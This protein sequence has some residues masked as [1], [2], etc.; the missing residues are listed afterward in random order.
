MD[1]IAEVTAGVLPMKLRPIQKRLSEAQ[2]V[3]LP[4]KVIDIYG[5][6]IGLDRQIWKLTAP[7]GVSR[8]N[9]NLTKKWI[10]D[11]LQIAFKTWIAES[12]ERRDP[13]TVETRFNGTL[14]CFR[15]MERHP[16]EIEHIDHH[17]VLKLRSVFQ[18][19]GHSRM[20]QLVYIRLFY[21]WLAD[22]E[23]SGANY[24]TAEMIREVTI[25]DPLK[26]EAV[27]SRDPAKGPLTA[28]ELDVVETAIKTRLPADFDTMVLMLFYELGL[29]PTAVSLLEQ[30]DFHVIV[31][32]NEPFFQ[33]DVP[34]VKKRNTERVTEVALNRRTRVEALKKD[35]TNER[36]E[37]N[38]DEV[39][40]I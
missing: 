19:G 6:P 5:I 28:E 25:P 9:W 39:A 3:V 24:Q 38:R 4:D 14:F 17:T 13:D 20:H 8:I 18:N 27:L 33:L 2:S 23:I 30:S 26:G 31:G 40:K 1:G 22:N 34:R 35:S 29:H 32:P 36:T 16:V 12:I 15:N 21:Y 7:G 10:S 11:D 37:A